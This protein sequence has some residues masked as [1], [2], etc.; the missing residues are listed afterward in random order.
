MFKEKQHKVPRIPV[1]ALM[2]SGYRDNANLLLAMHERFGDFLQFPFSKRYTVANPH[3]VQHILLTNKDNYSKDLGE[4]RLL[5]MLVGS[6]LLTSEGK[7]WQRQ[8]KLLQPLFHLREMADYFAMSEKVVLQFLDYWREQCDKGQPVDAARDMMALSMMLTSHCLLGYDIDIA[9]A[10]ILV[11]KFLFQHVHIC[12]TANAYNWLPLPSSFKFKLAKHATDKMIKEIVR[13]AASDRPTVLTAMLAYRD[14]KGRAFTEQDLHDQVQTIL[15]TGH[16]TTGLGLAWAWYL[17]AQH[18][19]HEQKMVTEIM[20]QPLPQQYEDLE[21][22]FYTQH[23]FQ[24]ALRLYPPI[25]TI[26]RVAL[27]NDVIEG[28]R[29]RKGSKLLINIY[30]LQRLSQYWQD[31]DQFDP[32]R[33]AREHRQKRHKFSYI[34]FGSGPHVCIANT[35]ALMQARLVMIYFQREFTFS[36]QNKNEPQGVETYISLKPQHK[37]WLNLQRRTKS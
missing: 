9:R 1:R 26:P 12:K 29:I 16:E 11:D 21:K 2:R 20:G 17:L 8:R 36:L 27:Q 35:L 13:H 18:P 33:F 22:F 15:A 14:E 31:A 4:Y 5:D 19:Q 7:R 24:E 30:A 6:G 32:E 28:F 25:W 37:I 10:Q 3:A 23:V 34:P